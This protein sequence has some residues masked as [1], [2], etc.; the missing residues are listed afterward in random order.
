VAADAG[1]AATR[2]PTPT[3]TAPVNAT[4][5]I[6]ARLLRLICFLLGFQCSVASCSLAFGGDVIHA[7][8]EILRSTRCVVVACALRGGRPGPEVVTGHAIETPR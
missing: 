6:L 8:T 7:P 5:A 3:T 1:V 4:V 2:P